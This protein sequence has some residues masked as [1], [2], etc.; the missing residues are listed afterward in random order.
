MHMYFL[1]PSSSLP[2][3]TLSLSL[4]S[5]LQKRSTLARETDV[6]TD[7]QSLHTSSLLIGTLGCRT[8]PIMTRCLYLSSSHS[9]ISA[10]VLLAASS[11][12]LWT[13]LICVTVSG[14]MC[15]L[16]TCNIHVHTLHILYIS[17]QYVLSNFSYYYFYSNRICLE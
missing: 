10:F 17:L 12:K 1:S 5:Q 2:P 14:W 6:Q 15:T 16:T 11:I 13:F 3:P 4:S 9:L 7:T 8:F